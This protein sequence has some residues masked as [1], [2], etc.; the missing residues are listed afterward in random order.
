MKSEIIVAIVGLVVSLPPALY[1][2]HTWYRRRSLVTYRPSHQ[3]HLSR[4]RSELFCSVSERGITLALR[5]EEGLPTVQR[6]TIFR[7]PNPGTALSC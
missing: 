7:T 2:L 3:K 6:E 4:R 1:A 5:V